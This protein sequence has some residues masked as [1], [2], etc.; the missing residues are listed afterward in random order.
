MQKTDDEDEE[1]EEQRGRPGANVRGGSEGHS[2]VD[3][4]YPAAPEAPALLVDPV[5]TEV[6]FISSA[7][8]PKTAS[9]LQ[10]SD[11]TMNRRMRNLQPRLATKHL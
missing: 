8:D 2:H 11:E 9:A 10:L 3:P 1:E 5:E 6:L 7:S 4:A